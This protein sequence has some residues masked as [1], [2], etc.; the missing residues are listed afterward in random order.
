MTQVDYEDETGRPLLT[1]REQHV[2][3]V[4]DRI[5]VTTDEQASRTVHGRVSGVHWT[6]RREY[7]V[8]TVAV[9]SDE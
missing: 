1:R 9:E 5:A 6:V 3:R 7:T 4:G 2:P 8:V